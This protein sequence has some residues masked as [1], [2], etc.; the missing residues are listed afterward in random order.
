MEDQSTRLHGLSTILS[1]HVILNLVCCLSFKAKELRKCI[2]PSVFCKDHSTQ[3]TEKLIECSPFPR[4]SQRSTAS[5]RKVHS[6]IEFDPVKSLMHMLVL[7]TL[8]S[9]TSRRVR[10]SVA[11]KKGPKI[12]FYVHLSRFF[13]VHPKESGSSDYFGVKLAT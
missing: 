2:W 8:P 3:T 9:M 4:T 5:A 13:L 6:Y 11:I 1:H 10:F 7:G 12:S